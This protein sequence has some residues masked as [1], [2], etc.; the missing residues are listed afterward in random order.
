M[1]NIIKEYKAS[2]LELARIKQIY[3]K[4]KEIQLQ[5]KANIIYGENNKGIHNEYSEKS[6]KSINGVKDLKST[7]SVHN[8]KGFGDDNVNKK[9]ERRIHQFENYINI[10]RQHKEPIEKLSFLNMLKSD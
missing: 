1:E 2:E 7:S 10:I 9:V 3:E 6:T 5:Q 4:F 8:V